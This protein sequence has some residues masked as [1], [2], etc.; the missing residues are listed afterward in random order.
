MHEEE[1]KKT[2]SWRDSIRASLN[3]FWN[4]TIPIPSLDSAIQLLRVVT[5]V[6]AP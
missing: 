5:I 2:E 4:E 1:K 6:V 3:V